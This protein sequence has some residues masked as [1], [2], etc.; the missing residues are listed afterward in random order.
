VTLP[1]PVAAVCDTF[2]TEADQRTPGAVGGLFL[3]GSLCWGEFFPGSDVDFV[4]LLNQP[5]TDSVLTALE[6]AHEA[7]SSLHPSL[8]FD[9]FHCTAPDLARPALEAAGRLPVFYQ[10]RFE[11]EGK[12]DIH[13]VTWHELAER[14]IV[15]RGVL[16]PIHTDTAELLAYTRTNLDTY[17]RSTLEQV[18][19]F[20]PERIGTH[21]PSVVWVVLGVARLHHLLATGSMTSKSGAGRYVLDSLDPRFHPIARDAL[22]IRERPDDRSE[23]ADPGQRGWDTRELLAWAVEDGTRR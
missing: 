11:R 10:G 14:A 3:H 19:D 22:R 17:W 13:P 21:E 18:D 15:V 7:T 23:Y 9:G 1:E 20:G 5:P 16:P 4:C 6:Q 2:L 8:A 12:L